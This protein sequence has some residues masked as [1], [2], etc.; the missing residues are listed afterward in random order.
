MPSVLM[1]CTGNICRSPMA[2]ALLRG[3]LKQENV[4]GVWRVSSAGTWAADGI[5]ASEHGVAVM[6]ERGL[7]TSF[8]RSR[9]VTR[10]LLA[11]ADLV[12]TM[13]AGHAESLRVEYPEETS[14]IHMLT[15]LVGRPYNIQD[16]IG[17]SLEDYRRTAGE[18]ATLIERGW[19]RIVELA[20]A[21]QAKS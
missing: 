4:P 18:L 12:L 3:K 14:K 21:N 6:Q 9:G 7:D 13:T 1:I 5:P 20:K 17:G 10:A 19:A 2:E 8:H 16:P 15:E 11:E